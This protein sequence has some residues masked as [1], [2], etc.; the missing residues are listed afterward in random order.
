MSG[1]EG[2]GCSLLGSLR[3]CEM[4]SLL[5]LTPEKRVSRRWTRIYN[6]I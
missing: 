5:D 6:V 3:A 2:L 4:E 1:A